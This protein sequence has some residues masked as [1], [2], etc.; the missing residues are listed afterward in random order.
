MPVVFR[1]TNSAV[2]FRTC[3]MDGWGIGILDGQA[4][5]GRRAFF[6]PALE[7]EK[8]RT[9]VN[10]PKPRRDILETNPEKGL[11]VG[12]GSVFVEQIRDAHA[13]I[14]DTH[15]YHFAVQTAAQAN[16]AAAA[17]GSKSVLHRVL[18][19]SLNG[20]GGDGVQPAI[21]VYLLFDDQRAAE[22]RLFYAQIVTHQL[23]LVLEWDK[24]SA[25]RLKNVPEDAGQVF[26]DLLGLFRMLLDER[27]D[28]IERV[29]EKMRI[30]LCPQR[31]QLRLC[32]L[33]YEHAFSLHEA[34]ARN[35][36]RQLATQR[37]KVLTLSKLIDGP[38][39]PL[40]SE[41][42]DTDGLRVSH[43]GN[44]DSGAALDQQFVDAVGESRFIQL[45]IARPDRP[46]IGEIRPDR[47]DDTLRQVRWLWMIVGGIPR[48][49]RS[50]GAQKNY[51]RASSEIASD[52]F[53]RPL[54]EGVVVEYAPHLLLQLL[55]GL[56]HGTAL[57]RE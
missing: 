43:D 31:H 34:Q 29:E 10:L 22:T 42:N 27:D 41:H 18:D 32:A 25:A 15:Q 3:P 16:G 37:A 54:N 9:P 24:F 52:D 21:R 14:R 45:C 50:I 11:F 49:G 30:D 7:A 33:A 36:E 55:H 44:E 57:A 13:T 39:L 48:S 8:I 38:P 19:Q 6:R 53:N 56:I 17:P 35:R 4:Q 46:A 26:D 20:E 28:R 12:D 2:R 51:G 23:E 47:R 1:C 40:H 5:L